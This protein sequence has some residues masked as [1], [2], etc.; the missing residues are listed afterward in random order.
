MSGSQ[1]SAPTPVYTR[2]KS[3]PEHCGH[4]V[5]LRLDVP[6]L[7]AGARG[8]VARDRQRAGREVHAGDRP[9]E[10]G[11]RKRVGPDV[12]LQ[13]H[14]VEAGEVTEPRPVVVDDAA[15]LFAVGGEPRE[16]VVVDAACTGHARLPVLQ[17]RGAGLVQV[18]DE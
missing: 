18:S 2:S 13:V 14:D 16:V 11:E 17:V 12:A 10:P 8:E 6:D 4:R 3:A 5:E 7:G 15:Q 1:L 9:A